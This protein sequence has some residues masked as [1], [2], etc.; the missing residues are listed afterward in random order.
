[1]L[2]TLSTYAQPEEATILEG[3]YEHIDSLLAE[4][5]GKVVYIDF[6]ASWCKP[7]LEMM[8]HSKVLQQ[9]LANED[10][11]FLYLGIRDKEAN[12]RQ[13]LQSLNLEGY[14]YLLDG[15]LANQAKK[16]FNVY[17]LPH[18]S[19]VDKNG[20]IAYVQALSPDY[21]ETEK[22]LRKLLKQ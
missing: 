8:P 7:C 18:Y 6:W 3:E 12:W 2:L 4:F 21:D 1:M 5:Q 13:K 20:E 22:D 19:I 15:N 16:Q 14:H 9:K 11:V 10:V 17:A